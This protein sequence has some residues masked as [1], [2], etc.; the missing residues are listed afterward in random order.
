MGAGERLGKAFSNPEIGYHGPVA[1]EIM[2]FYV[3]RTAE[4]NAQFIGELALIDDRIV[5]G[6]LGLPCPQ[7]GEEVG[8]ILCLD[9]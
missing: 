1:P 3:H 7:A 4:H 8:N 2:A 9:L 6:E 5:F